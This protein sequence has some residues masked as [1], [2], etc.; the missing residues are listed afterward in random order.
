MC[1]MAA[2][3]VYVVGRET[4]WSYQVFWDG[5]RHGRVRDALELIPRATF[6]SAIWFVH[7]FVPSVFIKVKEKL[8]LELIKS[9]VF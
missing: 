7:C 3:L 9:L 1:R 8:V 2:Q 5:L 4:D 6:C